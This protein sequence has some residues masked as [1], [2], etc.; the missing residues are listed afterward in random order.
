MDRERAEHIDPAMERDTPQSPATASPIGLPAEEKRQL[1]R[2]V[3]PFLRRAPLLRWS[4]LVRVEEGAPLDFGAFPFQV[5]LYEAF[6]DRNLASVDIMKSAQCGIS[7]LGVSHALHATDCW[8]ASVIYVLP[9]A[10]VA[11]QFSDTRIKPAIEDAPYLRDRVVSTDNKTVKRIGDAFLYVVGGESERQ[12]LSIPADVL[13]LDEYDHLKRANISKFHRR[14]GSPTS[15]N[16]VRRFSNP[17]YPED[18]IHGLFLASDQ[19]TWLVR[20]PKCQREAPVYYEQLDGSHHVDE[21]RGLRV[22]GRCS[23]ELGSA[24]VA[25]GRWV[26]TYPRVARR[27]YHVSKLIVPG[28][29]IAALVEAH[30]VTAEDDV[31][32]HYNFDLGEPYAPKGGSL[33][34]ELVRA[35]RRDWVC[36]DRYDGGDWVTMGVDVG[37]VLH[38][39]IS[40]WR[41]SG[42]AVP[43]FLGEVGEFSDLHRLMERYQVNFC[44]VDERPEERMAKEFRQAHRGRVR[45]IRWSSEEQHE[46]IREDDAQG[47]VT[48]RRT[49]AFDQTVAAFEAQARLLP[50]DL[51]PDYLRHC[52][53]PHRVTETNARGQKVARYVNQRRNDYFLAEVHDWLAKQIRGIPPADAS[54]PPPDFPRRRPGKGFLFH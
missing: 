28:E 1:L 31:T 23:R 12:A 27:G 7:A 50:K 47:I 37:K 21:E 39:R 13:I 49:W 17:S 42:N 35:C 26:P 30:R 51:P 24:E 6:G 18:G 52:T 54:G 3:S 10:D 33:S 19:R 45:L 46:D 53:A 9:T 38:V 5:E 8:G 29:D 43:L 44:I 48:V 15:L 14:L 22:C 2:H 16:L 41:S 40:E 34:E 36:P 4:R 32:S 25:S 11:G 20:C